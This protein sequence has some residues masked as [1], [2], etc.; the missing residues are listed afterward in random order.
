MILRYLI[1]LAVTVRVYGDDFI[2]EILIKPLPP[3]HLYVHF[4]FVTLVTS[5]NSCK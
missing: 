4:Q 1:F 3:T 5:E 2:E